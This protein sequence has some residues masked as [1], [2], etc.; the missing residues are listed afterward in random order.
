MKFILISLF[1]F[2]SLLLFGQ[3]ASIPK[4]GE[5]DTVFNKKNLPVKIKIYKEDGTK[6][7]TVKLSYYE[8]DTLKTYYHVASNGKKH[9]TE[10]N[11]LGLPQ[12]SQT[13]YR[14]DIS[15]TVFVYQ[16]D[17]L[18]NVIR[19]RA[20][21]NNQSLIISEAYTYE[22]DQVMTKQI[23]DSNDSLTETIYYYYKENGSFDFEAWGKNGT[24][25][26]AKKRISILPDGETEEYI[27]TYW[28]S[29]GQLSKILAIP[30]QSVNETDISRDRKTVSFQ[31]ENGKLITYTYFDRVPDENGQF[32]DREEG[33]IFEINDSTQNHPM[34]IECN[35]IMEKINR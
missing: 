1:L 16:Y 7:G 19:V 13:R 31:W 35:S 22:G 34:V 4:G 8:N 6:D 24:I 30:Y 15:Q 9:T 32:K 26:N 21:R 33:F 14:N 28:Y 12:I 25:K 27:F 11:S 3:T 29:E 17:S 5:A 10:Y 23:F 18:D 20:V 2:I